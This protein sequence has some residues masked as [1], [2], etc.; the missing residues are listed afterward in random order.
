MT[1]PC[2]TP[3]RLDLPAGPIA[4][5]QTTPA[6]EPR[7]TALLVPGY[8][9]S[10]E[11]YLPVLGPLAGAGYRCVA[12]DLP[13]QYESPGPTVPSAY[14]T[15]ALGRVVLAVT[16]ALG[17]GPVHL[18]GHSFGG[19]VAR[20][21]AIAEPRRLASLVLLGSGPAGL[22]GPRAD[23]M[24]A[25]EPVLAAGGL[26][27]VHAAL[28]QQARPPGAVAPPPAVREFLRRRFLASSAQGL[29]GMGDA[30]HT[31]PDRTAELRATGLP[32]LVAY[33][34]ADDAWSPAVQADMARRLGCPRE[35]IAG[36]AHSPAVEAPERTAD[37]LTHFWSEVGAG[38]TA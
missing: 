15:Q 26:P 30:L 34:E 17:A 27:A 33:G 5:L 6:G 38:P 13:G 31:E 1:L 23:Q 22:G 28:E 20:A 35:A 16:E 10:K 11:D 24:R 8:T 4:L 18:V 2:P 29:R 19:L 7:G 21:A 32:V 12:I 3:G 25:L 9:G 37:I 14:G 36:A